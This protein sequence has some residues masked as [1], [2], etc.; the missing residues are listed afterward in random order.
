MP[1][2]HKRLIEELKNL[3][4]NEYKAKVFLSLCKGGLM[5]AAE[6]AKDAKIIRGSIYDILK[7]F[8]EKGYCNEI[9][10]NRVLQYQVIDPD[11]IIDKIE[12][13]YKDEYNNKL[14]Q[15]KNTFKEVKSI[16]T[17]QIP[18]EDKYIN[19]ELIRGFNKHRVSK[20]REFLL[21]AE[22]EI[23]GMYHIK[24]IISEDSAE[25]ANEF[26]NKGGEIRSIYSFNL[27]FQVEKN[28]KVEDARKDD[29]IKVIYQ[30]EKMGEAV[31]ISELNIPNMTIVD[32]Q[33]VFISSTDKGVP[34]QFQADLIM[35]RSEFAKNMYDL[36]NYYWNDSMTI[37]ESKKKENL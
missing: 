36:F 30:F 25:V 6:I 18:A 21:S 8:V 1:T 4:F 19:I 3:G 29:F 22:E 27:D 7:S 26:I 23:C 37:D 10:T 15:L 5:T 9:D 12:R 34:K 31:R 35:R 14:S 33:N 2:E 32:R 16:Y 24:G 20:Y 28:G 11:V 17:T 13:D